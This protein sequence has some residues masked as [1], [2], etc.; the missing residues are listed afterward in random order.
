[1]LRFTFCENLHILYVRIYT[2]HD[3]GFSPVN[4]EYIKYL[5]IKYILKHLVFKI[6]LDRHIDHGGQEC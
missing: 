6:V 2:L 3:A 5:I 1:M 4:S